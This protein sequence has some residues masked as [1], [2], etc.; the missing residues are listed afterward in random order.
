MDDAVTYAYP[1]QTTS[2][3]KG[4]RKLRL[5]VWP[6]ADDAKL[7]GTPWQWT[8]S[9][10]ALDLQSDGS[11]NTLSMS[12]TIEK[13]SQGIPNAST[14]KLYNLA[15]NTKAMLSVKGLKA[16]LY[17]QD[18]YNQN[19]Q[20]V[21][22]GGI[23]SCFSERTGTDIVTT[24]FLL[25]KI[26]QFM[27]S[28]TTISVSGKPLQDVLNSWLPELNLKN[29]FI[30]GGIGTRIVQ[31]FCHMG[32][33]QDA[34][35]KLAFQESFSW[36]VNDESLFV[37][38][39]SETTGNTVTLTPENGL[40]SAIPML[41]GPFYA[42]NGVKIKAYPIPMMQCGDRVL[43]ESKINASTTN[44]KDLRATT[45]QMNLSTFENQ[46]EMDIVCFTVNPNIYAQGA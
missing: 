39:D 45:I 17:L 13:S 36:W 7:A 8:S 18:P 12:A 19:W 10:S 21:F 29:V 23:C 32:T 42:Q 30:N 6:V 33:F 9:T 4:P 35:N 37:L 3:V 5:L 26:I 2:S 34:L 1:Q 28:S 25:S 15:E 43:V 41:S 20:E 16:I 11:R 44:Q 46:W 24:V 31:Q 40:I 38:P 22:S 14:V 27:T